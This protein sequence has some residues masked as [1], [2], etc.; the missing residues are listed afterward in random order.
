[1][2]TLA[3]IPIETPY[4]VFD[5]RTRSVIFSS[6]GGDIPPDVALLPVVRVYCCNDTIY[7]DVEA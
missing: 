7:I 1:M 3:M 4:K 6:A 5:I 2:L